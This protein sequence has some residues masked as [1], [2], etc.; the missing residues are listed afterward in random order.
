[1]RISIAVMQRAAHELML[2]QVH[3]RHQV[4]KMQELCHAAV[5]GHVTKRAAL[6]QLHV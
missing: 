3:M 4:I 6:G 1:M 2:R 5:N